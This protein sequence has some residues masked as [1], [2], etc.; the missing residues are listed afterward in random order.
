MPAADYNGPDGFTFAVND[1]RLR[2][3]AASVALTVSEVNDPPVPGADSATARRGGDAAAAA[4][5]PALR[6]PCGVIYGDP[7]LSSF[8]AALYDFQAVGEFIAA[9]STTDDFELQARFVRR[10]AAAHGVDRDR[11]WRCASPATVSPSTA[12]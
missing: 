4:S 3:E 1:G 8:D 12:P 6:L 7:H 11:A 5:A 9:K 10:A 2:S